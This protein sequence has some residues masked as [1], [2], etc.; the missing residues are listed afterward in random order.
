MDSAYMGNVMA[1]IGQ[2][3]WGFNMVGTM[4]T[5]RTGVPAAAEVK[6]MK[7]TSY[8]S[9]LWQHSTKPL[10]YAAWSD[11]T[12][13]KTWFNFH[14]PEILDS[15][16]GVKQKK[17]DE[18]GRPERWQSNVACPVQM[19]YCTAFHL[20]DKG[21]GAEVSYNMGGKSRTHN[22]TPKLVFQFYNIALNKIYKIYKGLV[23][24]ED[25]NCIC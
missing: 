12:I 10:V 7:K 16:F 25:G 13:I 14:L 24:A 23:M 6:K 22:W 9:I 18:N 2:E 1:Q 21:N 19:E 15:E 11:N 5:N 17:R 20:I 4:Q 8:E 3:E